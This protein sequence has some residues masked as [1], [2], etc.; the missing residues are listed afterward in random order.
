M[1]FSAEVQATNLDTVA[2]ALRSIGD[3]DL[4]RELYRGLNR[5]TTDLKKDAKDEAV[6]RLPRRGGLGAKVGASRLSTH[7]R[8]GRN[9][10]VIIRAKSITQ[11]ASIDAGVVKHP[12]YG[13]RGVWV[14]QE[15][16]GGWFTDPMFAGR[17]EIVG[18]L[19]VLLEDLATKAAHRIQAS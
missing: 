13:N 14:T 6:R 18:A 10:G 3:K 11:L 17:D 15:V 2:R 19:D 7:R 4:S 5:V 9:P 12:V 1:A 16:T 8:G